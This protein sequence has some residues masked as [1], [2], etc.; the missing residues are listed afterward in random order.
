MTIK[1]IIQ[2]LKESGIDVSFY[3]RKD[4]GIRITRIGGETFRGSK[5]NIK[6]REMTGQRL[7]ESQSRALSNLKTPKGRG[8]YNKRR[9]PKIDEK[10]RKTITRLQRQ[11]RKAGKAE[12]KPTLRNYRYVLKHEGKREADRLLKQ[13][14]RRI[15]GL[16]YT[17]NVDALLSRIRLNKNKVKNKNGVQQIIDRIHAM[18]EVIKESTLK[19]IVD[20][21][22]PLYHWEQ[23]VISTEEFIQE[24]SLILD[25]N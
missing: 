17:E 18:R 16:A 25:L 20:I 13:A 11:Y 12:G 24:M 6:A 2:D 8:S 3:K 19:K 4:G 21:D 1:E 7:S 23:G 22:G 10:T 15:L 9:K 5:G 14:E